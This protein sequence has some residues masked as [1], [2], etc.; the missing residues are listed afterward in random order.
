MEEN[1]FGPVFTGV[2]FIGCAL[3]MIGIGISNIKSKKPCGFY[4]GEKGPG[5]DELTDKDAW[6]R[7]HGIMWILYGAA[8]IVTWAAGIFVE[9]PLILL[10]YLGGFLLPIPI[11]IG[12]HQ[13]LVKTY[14]KK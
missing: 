4:S 10:P 1:L 12:Y 8:I 2:I 7:K 6:N 3:L 9:G 13:H 11:M 5:E 14:V